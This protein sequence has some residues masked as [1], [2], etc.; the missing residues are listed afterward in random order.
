MD[1]EGSLPPLLIAKAR[2]GVSCALVALT[3]AVTTVVVTMMSAPAS[4]QTVTM[5]VTDDNGSKPAVYAGSSCTGGP[6]PTSF[7]STTAGGTTPPFSAV[8]TSGGV[9]SMIARYGYNIGT[10]PYTCQFTLSEAINLSTGA[11]GTPTY[12]AV[13][14]AGQYPAPL[15]IAGA[16]SIPHAPSCSVTAAFSIK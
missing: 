8:S 3:I 7:P 1:D 15:C 11:C 16:P 5:T 2:P 14:T 4:A 9:I 10:Q 13:A 12:S 6:C